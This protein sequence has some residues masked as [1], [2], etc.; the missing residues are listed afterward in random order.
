MQSRVLLLL[1]ILCFLARLTGAGSVRCFSGVD[2]LT[3]KCADLIGEGIE[4]EDCCLNINYC[5]TTGDNANSHLCRPT[6]EWSDWSIW[7]HCSVTCLE[8]VQQRRRICYGKGR[9]NCHGTERLQTRACVDQECCPDDGSWSEW[10]L[11]STCSVTCLTGQRVRSRSCSEPPPSCGG[12]CRGVS[13]QLQPCDTKQICPTHGSWAPWGPWGACDKS[14]RHEGSELVPIRSR[15]RVCSN[16]APSLSPPGTPCPGNNTESSLCDFLPFCPVAGSWGTWS[17]LSPCSVSCGVGKVR[18]GRTC[19]RPAPK[20]GGAAC[21]GGA[22]GDIPCN[23]RI[24]CPVHGSWTQW[25]WW[26]YCERPHFNISCRPYVG[27]QKRTRRCV[28]QAHNGHPCPG[29]IIE[30]RACYNADH[31]WYGKGSWTDWNAWSL[32]EPPCGKPSLR[33]RARSCVPIYPN[34]PNE[35]TFKKKAPIYFWGFPN[36]E[37]DDLL[38]ERGRLAAG[39]AVS[40]RSRLRLK[41]VTAFL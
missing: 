37:C 4:E 19:D 3:G 36:Y 26:S 9:G 38:G 25:S 29:S 39:P 20:Y 1:G 21:P 33:S 16:P 8:G 40:E 18:Q 32:C 5:F 10:S 31:C 22:I 17:A 27:Q 7:S 15:R 12:Q 13:L 6:A 24:P 34:Y 14:C 23:T 41:E 11:W 2:R 30:I 35:T 28:G